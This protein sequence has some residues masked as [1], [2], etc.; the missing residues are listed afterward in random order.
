MVDFASER[1]FRERV[2]KANWS[3]SLREAKC[4]LRSLG[5]SFGLQTMKESTFP[6]PNMPGRFFTFKPRLALLREVRDASR[7]LGEDA[8]IGFR[9][10]GTAPIGL[11]RVIAHGLRAGPNAT[12]EN[13]VFIARGYTR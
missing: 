13:L 5:Y 8:N 4:I 7:F 11:Q 2:T 9:Y 6:I 3:V 12:K 10:H 1:L